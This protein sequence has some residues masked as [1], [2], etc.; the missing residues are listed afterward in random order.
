[1]KI[2]QLEQLAKNPF[3]KMSHAQLEQLAA[4]RNKKFKA[5][6]KNAVVKHSTK[7]TKHNPNLKEE[8]ERIK[9]SRN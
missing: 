7:F 2:E 3:Y 8:D 5:D 4:Y 6:E 9:S 1:M